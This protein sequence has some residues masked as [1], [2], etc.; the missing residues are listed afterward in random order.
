MNRNQSSGFTILEIVIVI[1]ILGIL[2]AVVVPRILFLSEDAHRASVYGFL[3][4]M[5]TGL[6]LYADNQIVTAGYKNYPDAEDFENPGGAAFGITLGEISDSWS[7][8]SS[9]SNKVDF[10]YALTDPNT[11][12]RYSSSGDDT[13]TLVIRSGPAY[14][15]ED[16]GSGGGD[17]DDDHGD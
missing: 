13:Y 16:Q 14:M 9:G 10:V 5:K 8:S 2:A 15:F 4:S 12:V 6:E 1:I 3:G 7:I 11:I 17:D